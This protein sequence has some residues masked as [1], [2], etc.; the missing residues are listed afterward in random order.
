MKAER[1]RLQSESFC[2]VDLAYSPSKSSN[3]S[4]MVCDHSTTLGFGSRGRATHTY[5]KTVNPVL[6]CG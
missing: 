1:K 5:Y 6:T 2:M 3:L 4:I